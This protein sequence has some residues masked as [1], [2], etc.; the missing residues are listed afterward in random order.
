[1]RAFLT[2]TWLLGIGA[3]AGGCAAEV[4]VDETSQEARA[5]Q[6]VKL[7]LSHIECGEDG[8]VHAHFV[9]LFAGDAT[10]GG[11]SG[12]YNDGGTFA[13]DGPY[14]HSGNVW[15]YDVT[16]PSGDIDITG[17][18]ATLANGSTV[19]LHN[20]H[21]YAGDYDC[22]GSTC[23]VVVEPQDLICFDRPLGDEASECGAFG[24]VPASK[25]DDLEGTTHTATTDA[26]VAI[27]KSGSGGCGPGNSA[28]R[29][30]VDVSAG[31]VLGSPSWQDISHV[32]YCDCPSE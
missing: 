22:G 14:K 17:A 30:Y 25:D 1:M 26:Y 20:P 15:H 5:A 19:S 29:V 16:L 23:S 18:T 27:V 8:A 11:L 7:N 13:V 28:Y 12:T 24:L 4:D 10:P 32:T 21:D 6:A 3:L 2:A 31:D 9:L